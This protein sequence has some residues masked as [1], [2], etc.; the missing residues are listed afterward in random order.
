MPIYLGFSDYFPKFRRNTS[1]VVAIIASPFQVIRHR[2][3]HQHGLWLCQDIVR[4][5][6]HTPFSLSRKFS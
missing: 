4:G 6:D 3:Q 5:E 2:L 1:A